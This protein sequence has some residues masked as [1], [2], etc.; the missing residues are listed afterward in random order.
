ML[1]FGVDLG[2]R[3]IAAACPQVHFV[4]STSLEKAADRREYPTELAAGR[5]LGDRLVV[6]LYQHNLDVVAD[7]HRW[8]FFAERPFLRTARPNVQTA[9]GMSISAGAALTQLPGAVV[10]LK[11]PT[12]WKKELCGNGNADKDEIR[13]V[14]TAREPAL[15]AL[16]GEDQDRYDALGIAL[17]G[18]NLADDGSL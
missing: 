8:L 4:W 16:C 11:H 18:A 7:G 12:V 15:A 1:T 2:T 9:V 13:R 3:R 17:A 6:A 14:V 10:L 5:K